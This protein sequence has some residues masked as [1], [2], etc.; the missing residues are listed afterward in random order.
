MMVGNGSSQSVERAQRRRMRKGTRSCV[1]CR[2]RK[3]RCIF[4]AGSRICNGCKTHGKTCIEQTYNHIKEAGIDKRVGL[5]DRVKELE[6]L[7]NQLMDKDN[8]DS[9]VEIPER[10]REKL[11]ERRVKRQ[12][13]LLSPSDSTDIS[14][15]TSR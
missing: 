4:I 15:G 13:G 5:K 11:K 14:S 10:Y 12:G 9:K 1:E 2:T 6:A 7:V 3:T 8:L